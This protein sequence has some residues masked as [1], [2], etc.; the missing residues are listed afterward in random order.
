MFPPFIIQ[1]DDQSN[2]NSIKKKPDPN[3]IIEREHIIIFNRGMK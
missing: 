3:L 1:N 2:N